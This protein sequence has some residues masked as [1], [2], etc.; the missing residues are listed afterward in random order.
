[1]FLSVVDS[2]CT[3]CHCLCAE[4]KTNPFPILFLSVCHIFLSFLSHPYSYPLSILFPLFPI[5]FQSFCDPIL[6]LSFCCLPLVFSYVKNSAE[7][8]SSFS[9]HNCQWLAMPLKILMSKV[10]APTFRGKHCMIGFT[11]LGSQTLLIYL[12]QSR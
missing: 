5:C 4:M 1:M 10:T 12:D 7:P 8:R 3:F 2:E 6:F 9:L 11:S